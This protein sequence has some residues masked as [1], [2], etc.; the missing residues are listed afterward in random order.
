MPDLKLT[1]NDPKTGKSFTKVVPETE[2]SFFRGR[3]I[4]ESIHGDTFGMKGYELVITGG[5]DTSGFPMRF[6]VEGQGR[7]RP[8]LTKGPGVHIK[9]KGMK[10][11]KINLETEKLTRTKLN[12]KICR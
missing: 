5:S 9:R 7:K 3:K 4:K 10:T 6:D 11:R 8:L 2:S 1:I 12:M